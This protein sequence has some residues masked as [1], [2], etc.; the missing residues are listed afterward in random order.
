MMRYFDKNNNRLVYVGRA[1]G[2]AYWDQRW[3]SEGAKLK[4]RVKVKSDRL[5]IRYTKKYLPIRAKILEGGCGWGEKVSALHY[6][7]Y[8]AYGIDYAKETIKEVNRC[9]P[10]LKIKIGDVRDL[11]F[12]DNFFD[13]YWSL[14]VIE[15]FYD[16]YGKAVSEMFRVLKPEGYLF[17]TVPVMSPLRKTK[18]KRGKYPAY[19]ES[20]EMRENFYQFAFDPKDIVNDL[21]NRGFKLVEAKPYDGIKGL[22]DE[23]LVLKPFLQYLYDKKNRAS[24]VMKRM[25]DIVLRIF[26]NHICLFVMR[27]VE[28]NWT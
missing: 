2:D 4:K 21:N 13:G 24:N 17:L 23:V 14:G 28:V 22:K 12:P 6:H 15:H 3:M 11:P 26:A 18:V 10:E 9:A 5:I 7:G 8:D 16:G 25:L 20:G 27:R 19:K 1:A